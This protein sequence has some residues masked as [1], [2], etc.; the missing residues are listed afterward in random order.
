MHEQE[1]IDQLQQCGDVSAQRSR[2]VGE[3]EGKIHDVQYLCYEKKS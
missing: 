1:E 2:F 3:H